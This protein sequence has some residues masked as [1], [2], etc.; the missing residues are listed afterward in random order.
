M[1]GLG[2]AK[3]ICL[4]ALKDSEITRGYCMDPLE[5]LQNNNKNRTK[6]QSTTWHP[7]SP[8]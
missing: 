7:K 2:A 5:Q 1:Q 8:L 6:N 4:N 3:E